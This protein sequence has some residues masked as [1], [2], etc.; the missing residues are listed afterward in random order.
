MQWFRV[1]NS[2]H[3]VETGEAATPEVFADT[4]D[5]LWMLVD[6]G[7]RRAR[8]VALAAS[9][10]SMRFGPT[11]ALHDAGITVQPGEVVAVVGASGSGKS[12]FL[13]CIAGL[14]APTSGSI[15]FGGT[16]MTTASD[17]ERTTIRRERFG[18][19]MQHG[20]LI[21][22]MTL[23]QNA[24]IPLRL[25]GVPKS[26]A[27]ARVA[28]L[29]KR[30]GVSHLADRLPGEVSGGEQ[31]R[32]AVVRALVAQPMIVFADE[33]TGAL[34][35]A[36]GAA[37]ASALFDIARELDSA[38]V[39]VTHDDSLASAADRVVTMADGRTS[40]PRAWPR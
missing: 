3:G 30:L 1:A 18:F 37:V 17:A 10:V 28:P 5:R 26:A 23:A 21:P 12:T 9:R 20:R 40:Q 7:V 16:E 39:I 38:V 24:A 35:S 14:L 31:Q 32:V 15:L 6:D 11:W 19:V 27:L 4:E 33:P 2:A 13:H 34:D 22:E 29:M 8:D 36:N 25:L